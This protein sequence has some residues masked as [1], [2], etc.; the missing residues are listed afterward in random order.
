MHQRHNNREDRGTR[1]DFPHETTRFQQ[2]Q[3][4]QAIWK[5]VREKR[6]GAVLGTFGHTVAF[7]LIRES[8]GF[9]VVLKSMKYHNAQA[10]PILSSLKDDCTVG[11]VKSRI[12]HTYSNKLAKAG[13][14]TWRIE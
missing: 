8:S 11:E 1:R 14:L 6:D 10:V 4:I 7:F 3:T 12:I 2:D 5:T 13:R 9:K